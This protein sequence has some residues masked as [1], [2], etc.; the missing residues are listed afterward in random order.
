M[1]LH[2]HQL[3]AKITHHIQKKGG[4][5]YYL[6]L[7]GSEAVNFSLELEQ[8]PNFYLVKS[9]F[10]KSRKVYVPSTVIQELKTHHGKSNS[11]TRFSFYK[12][13]KKVKKELGISKEIELSPHTL[14]RCYTTYHALNGVPL[15]VLSKVLGH[16]S[17]KTTALYWGNEK[18][19]SRKVARK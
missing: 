18:E 17:V 3:L 4:T 7:L 16:K 10:K 8:K 5:N 9:K 11:L 14:R 13:L 15:P 6:F 2:S 12:F 1:M 19:I